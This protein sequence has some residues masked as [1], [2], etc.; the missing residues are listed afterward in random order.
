M[1]QSQRKNP[2]YRTLK[3]M[4]PFTL[5]IISVY[6][7]ASVHRHL[8]KEVPET[9]NKSCLWEG[10][11]TSGDRGGEGDN[12]LRHIL[13]SFDFWT[14]RVYYLARIS[15]SKIRFLR[16]LDMNIRRKEVDNPGTRRWQ[17]SRTRLPAC[18]REEMEGLVSAK[19]LAWATQLMLPANSHLSALTLCLDYV[20]TWANAC[21]LPA[22]WNGRGPSWVYP[23]IF[24][25][26]FPT[27]AFLVCFIL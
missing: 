16:F 8:W 24:P 23:T 21:A 12:I 7:C 9:G 17:M 22:C 5:Q 11:W 2:R 25:S 15:T 6:M 19:L 3:S 4:L 18:G 10:T 26:I 14:M 1:K 27:S 13:M 20:S